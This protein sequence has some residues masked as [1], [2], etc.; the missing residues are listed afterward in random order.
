MEKTKFDLL[1]E[2]IMDK[3]NKS[4]ISETT[5][6]ASEQIVIDVIEDEILGNDV[7]LKEDWKQHVSPIVTYVEENLPEDKT[8]KTIDY[9][10]LVKLVQAALTEFDLFV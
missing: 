5:D 1:F 7:E 4:E 2:E 3:F 8:I 10:D 6:I 9:L